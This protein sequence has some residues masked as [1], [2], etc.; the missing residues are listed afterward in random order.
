M[1]REML[2]CWLVAAA[3]AMLFG[4][5]VVFASGFGIVPGLIGA[6]AIALLRKSPRRLWFGLGAAVAINLIAIYG[7]HL[8]HERIT[9]T[10]PS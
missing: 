7:T 5:G 8:G 4:A 6:A 9:R 3:V 1:W 10:S 2:A